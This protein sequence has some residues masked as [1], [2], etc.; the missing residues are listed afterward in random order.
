MN[1]ETQYDI[2]RLKFEQGMRWDKHRVPDWTPDYVCSLVD[3]KD[4]RYFW[5][6]SIETTRT[7]ENGILTFRSK[8]LSTSGKFFINSF[9]ETYEDVLVHDRELGERMTGLNW[10][11]VVRSTSNESCWIEQFVDGEDILIEV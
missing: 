10:K 3:L 8:V 1:T 4:Y 6:E 5:F 9:V 7:L 2:V 11:H